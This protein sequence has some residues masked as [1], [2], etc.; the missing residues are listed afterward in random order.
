MPS[1]L[2]PTKEEACER[3]SD[4]VE[5]AEFVEEQMLL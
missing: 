2:L 4:A 5:S 1:L 3:R